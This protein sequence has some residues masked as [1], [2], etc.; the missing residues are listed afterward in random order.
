[1]ENKNYEDLLKLCYQGPLE[2]ELWHSFL[3]A[4][5]GELKARYVTLILRSP[6]HGDLGVILSA[7]DLRGKS[8]SSQIKQY[9]DQNPFIDMPVNKALTIDDIVNKEA[10]K[11]TDYYQHYLKVAEIEYILGLRLED[12]KGYSARL[13]ISRGADSEDFSKQDKALI[14]KLASHLT[15]SIVLYSRI[16]HAQAQSQTYQ[17]AFDHMEMGCIILDQKLK[18]LSC[19][20]VAESLLQE[21]SSLSIKEQQLFVGNNDEHRQFKTLV[22]S[23]LSHEGEDESDAVQAFRVGLPYS[24]AGLGL[25]CRRL[26]P[27]ATPDSG[28]SVAIFFSDPEKPRQHNVTVLGQLFGLTLSEAKLA[29]LLAN[30]L[31]LD[32]AS[33]EMNITRNTAKSH[34]SS[35]F[36]KTGVSRQPSLVQLILRS[37]ASIG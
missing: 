22:K 5:K 15:Q 33:G 24:M 6:Q 35:A 3:Y 8:Y 25:L 37:V 23:L 29:L 27:T 32:E 28:P 16:I 4:L 26:Q 12:E 20:N 19:N 30:G 17:E 34:L 10:F 18:V 21:R 14:N 9:H 7:H 31:S 1:M 36:S 2:Q 11:A 13:I